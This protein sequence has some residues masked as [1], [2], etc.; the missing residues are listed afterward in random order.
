[1]HGFIVPKNGLQRLPLPFA[2]FSPF[3]SLLSLSPHTALYIFRTFLLHSP[4]LTFSRAFSFYS[5][6]CPYLTSLLLIFYFT[7][8]SMFPLL[9]LFATFAPYPALYIS[10]SFSFALILSHSLVLSLF[11]HSTLRVL[12]N[13]FLIFYLALAD[14]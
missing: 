10:L 6:L 9:R 11:M 8:A 12:Y 14:L 4:T 2:V 1:M 13:L 3:R 7:L 5:S